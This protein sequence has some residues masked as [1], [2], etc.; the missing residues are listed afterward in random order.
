MLASRE[1]HQE[2]SVRTTN[3]LLLSLIIDQLRQFHDVEYLLGESESTAL[4]QL[5][6]E[7]G[8]SDV[9]ADDR[10]R[11]SS[12]RVK[13]RCFIRMLKPVYMLV[14]VVPATY[15]DLLVIAS[16]PYETNSTNLSSKSYD[17]DSTGN[18]AAD[19]GQG[20]E[21]VVRSRAFLDFVSSAASAGST[22]SELAASY[23]PDSQPSVILNNGSTDTHGLESHPQVV[24]ETSVE[25]T[26][27]PK[28]PN[29]TS[30]TSQG[31]VN[32]QSTSKDSS[33]VLP[34]FVFDCRF[35]VVCDEV[36]SPWAQQ[37]PPDFIEDLTFQVPLVYVFSSPW[38]RL[39]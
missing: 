27:D 39:L 17:L 13:W 32:G 11:S 24:M 1:S 28:V 26:I 31:N 3:N 15:D 19:Q 30:S 8:G 9:T 35:S 16:V 36:A 38:C 37:R 23:V 34:I 5:I 33:L 2:N 18:D 22:N 4:L 10:N 29:S 14:T 6:R 7:R 21:A 12:E 25:T 20:K